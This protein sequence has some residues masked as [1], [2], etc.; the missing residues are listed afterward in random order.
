M[1]ARGALFLAWTAVG[2]VGAYGL[3]YALTGYGLL[4]LGVAAA[5]GHMLP[6]RRWPEMIGLAEGAGVFLVYAAAQSGATGLVVAGSL[7]AAASLAGYAIAG[8]TSTAAG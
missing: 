8:R 3:P 2:A 7:L 4:I 1:I 5:I 6:G